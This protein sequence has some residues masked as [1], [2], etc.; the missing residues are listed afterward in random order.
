[1]KVKTADKFFNSIDFESIVDTVHGIY[2][3]DGTMSMLLD[4]ERV[5]DDA[6][7]YAFKNWI[8]GE[9][10]QGPDIGRYTVTCVFMWPQKLMPDPRGALRLLKSGCRIEFAKSKIKVPIKV[11]TENDFEE[12]THYPKMI[13]RPVWFVKIEIP[14]EL[15]DDIKEGS[16]EIAD[17]QIDLSDIDDAYNEDLD[18]STE[19]SEEDEVQ[20]Q[21]MSGNELGF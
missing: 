10:V 15:V 16:I 4:F 19:H 21:D 8:K 3:S 11:E 20:Q 2:T 17:K 13:D 12:G 14:L 9:L 5:L 7:L 1:M 6:D 18:K